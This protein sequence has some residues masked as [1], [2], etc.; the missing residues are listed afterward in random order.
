MN[1]GEF[2]KKV[3]EDGEKMMR[4]FLKLVGWGALAPASSFSCSLGEKHKLSD[5]DRQ[6]H[7]VDGI[8]HYANPLNHD[9]TDVVLCSAKHNQDA[10]S[11][12]SKAYSHMKDL[13]Q[14]LE[15]APKDFSFNSE[16]ENWDRK[17][18][19][20]GLLFWISSNPSERNESM[21][22]KISDGFLKEDDP[23]GKP[24]LR[25][26]NFDSI[27][28]LDNK[29]VTF[30]YSS[31]KT[32]QQ[33][34]PGN[35]INFLYP[36]TGLNNSPHDLQ[37][38]G[39]I[40]PIQFMNTS[41]LPIVVDDANSVKVL[42][43]CDIDFDK[44]YLKRII[45]LAHKTCGLAN[46][47]DIFF[48][49]YDVTSD[50][51]TEAVVKQMFP[52]SQLISKTTI[53]RINEYDFVTLKEDQVEQIIV[54]QIAEV[55][56]QIHAKVSDD[57]DRMLPFGEIIKPILASSILSETDLKS[58]LVRKGIF[59]GNKDKQHTVPLMSTMLFSPEELNTL[60][61]LLKEKEDKI[62]TVLRKTNLA[63]K[64]ISR[65]VLA[66]NLQ[67]VMENSLDS[68]FPPTN[69]KFHKKPNISI[70][71]SDEI[72]ISFVLEKRNST[73]DLITGTQHNNGALIFK[74]ENDELIGRI[75]Y[76]SK[77]VYTYG[78][79]LFKEIEQELLSKAVIKDEFLSIYFNDFDNKGRIEFFLNFMTT[80]GMV[81]FSDARLE[82]ILVKPDGDLPEVLP[83]DL[84]SL[85]GKVNELALKGTSLDSVHYFTDEYKKSLLMQKVR[86]KYSY[87]F[88][89][90][91]G[92]CTIELDFKGALEMGANTELHFN[93][94][95]SKSKSN[96]GLD[97]EKL[98]NDLASKF[99]AIIQERYKKK[100]ELLLPSGD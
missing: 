81:H 40:L 71:S 62:K 46:K 16:F 21:V 63:Q 2:P 67:E 29:K 74:I 88:G 75:D 50:S 41:I 9:E 77:E 15:C 31:V 59:I 55:R 94:E 12:K 1:G 97:Q 57:L 38:Y 93:L 44:E 53:R 43:F 79:K 54:N 47:V 49:D 4:E 92:T 37:P 5:S 42:I 96:K 25:G 82:Y 36:H 69:C 52:D 33:L 80:S 98:N 100:K 3:G 76:T 95:V 90:H 24:R 32:A 73:K 99:N 58:F 8:F 14:S 56:P 85:K 60:K 64:E 13:A 27:Y 87:E 26:I 48:N 22:D 68:V 66:S 91:Q 72:V 6:G 10:Y 30:I 7:N 28:V 51:K 17:K 20:K 39:K 89:L 34:Y 70:G 11:A 61:F 23:D 19:Y 86:I 35:Q 18:V 84:E 83:F 78:T 65:D 45:W